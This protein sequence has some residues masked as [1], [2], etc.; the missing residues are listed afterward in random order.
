[1]QTGDNPEVEEVK[2]VYCEHCHLALGEQELG[3]LDGDDTYH[4]E[5]YLILQWQPTLRL[6]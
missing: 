4:A 3:V 5:C 6:L 2:T 1:M